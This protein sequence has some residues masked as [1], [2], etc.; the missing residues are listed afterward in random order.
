MI[1]IS[2]GSFTPRGGRLLT[3]ILGLLGGVVC[4]S[5][6]LLRADVPSSVLIGIVTGSIVAAGGLF[7]PRFASFVFRGWNYATRVFSR[8]ACLYVIAVCYFVVF[9]VAGQAG[10]SLMLQR[11]AA[12]ESLWSRRPQRSAKP[13]LH[14]RTGN[15]RTPAEQAGLSTFVKVLRESGSW[16]AMLLIPFFGLLTILDL[17]TTKEAPS[18]IY[19]LF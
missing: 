6:S 16:S 14:P 19:T 10:S 5:V 12:G 1:S 3:L 15:S 8:Y 13:A 18:D 4:F 9:T 7:S 2:I 11:R 17:D